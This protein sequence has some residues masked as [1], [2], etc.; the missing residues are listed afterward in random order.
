MSIGFTPRNIIK[1]IFDF[2]KSCPF[3]EEYNIDMTP[4]S[5]QRLVTDKPDGSA[6]DYVG[7]TQ[8]SSNKDLVKD[9]Y[10]AR[11]ANFQLWLLRKSNHNVLRHEIADF[12]WN[13]EQ[14]VEHCQVYGLC[15]KISLDPSDQVIEVMS[16]D[17]GVYFAEWEGEESSLYVI[18]LHVVY[19]NRY[20]GIK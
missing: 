11:Q 17:N 20:Q 12:L 1:P 13:F 4:S 18:Q 10:T 8:I 7:S 6:L 15:P 3:L 16:A 14:W 5:I 2:V 9:F 19:Y